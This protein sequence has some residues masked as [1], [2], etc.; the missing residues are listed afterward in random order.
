MLPQLSQ[1]HRASVAQSQIPASVLQNASLM[2]FLPFLPLEN[3]HDFLPVGPV[4]V[5]C[6]Q[7]GPEPLKPPPAPVTLVN[8]FDPLLFLHYCFYEQ[9]IQQHII[10]N[11]LPL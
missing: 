6:H 8:L 11:V 10:S 9:R 4:N 7:N 5:P 1:D 3:S 2:I